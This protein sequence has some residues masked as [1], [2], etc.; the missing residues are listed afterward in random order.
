MS[1]G[2]MAVAFYR[3]AASGAL[4]G[5]HFNLF[6]SGWALSGVLAGTLYGRPGA[7]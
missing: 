7:R 3:G 6:V 4:S 2:V 1:A 5:A